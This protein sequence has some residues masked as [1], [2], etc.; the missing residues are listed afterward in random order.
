MRAS[1]PMLPAIKQSQIEVE[2][3][4][5]SVLR[6]FFF[7]GQYVACEKYFIQFISIPLDSTPGSRYFRL[8]RMPVPG[9][10]L[11]LPRSP[12]QR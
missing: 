4:F 2:I 6:V 10:F 3:T 8:S 7:T 5:L 11:G 1:T 12:S 9:L